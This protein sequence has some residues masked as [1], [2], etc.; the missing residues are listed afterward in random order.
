MNLTRKNDVNPAKL[1]EVQRRAL[2]D[3]ADGQAVY[4]GLWSTVTC[5]RADVLTRLVV[6]GLAR[7][8]SDQV[9]G[10]RRTNPR[11][12]ARLVVITDAGRDALTGTGGGA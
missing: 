11:Y 1:T 3:I 8:D 7:I 2:V 12:N 4:D 6:A 9:V 10:K 5:M